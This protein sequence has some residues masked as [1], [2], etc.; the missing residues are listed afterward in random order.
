MWT[1]IYYVGAAAAIDVTVALLLCITYLSTYSKYT[2][3]CI[4]LFR[5]F[6][7]VAKTLA[8]ELQHHPKHN[9]EVFK[10]KMGQEG[11]NQQPGQGY[12]WQ[13]CEQVPSLSPICISLFEFWPWLKITRETEGKDIFPHR[14]GLEEDNLSVQKGTWMTRS[15]VA[16][17]LLEQQR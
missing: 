8:A 4:S 7:T 1:C 17:A 15:L 6:T 2:E 9:A 3:V 16:V 11:P 12:L 14:S 10:V 5:Q 13:G